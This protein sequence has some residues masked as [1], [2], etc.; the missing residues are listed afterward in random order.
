MFD[1]TSLIKYI[2]E[3]IVVGAVAYFIPNTK[4]DIG[5]VIILALTSASIFAI[6]DQ[7]SPQISRP[8]RRGTGFALGYQQVGFGHDDGS[9]CQ[10]NSGVCGYAPGTVLSDQ[11]QYIC[12]TDNGQCV[13][14][15][16]NSAN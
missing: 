10:M 15:P 6:L 1:W 13:V 9:I 11:K 5:S 12:K 16:V 14:E 3:G 7:F 8:A 2:L 4:L